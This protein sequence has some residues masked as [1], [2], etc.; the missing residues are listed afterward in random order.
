MLRLAA[1][2]G[3]GSHRWQLELAGAG[4][5]VGALHVGQL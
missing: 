2:G 3:G 1:G 5:P 4:V